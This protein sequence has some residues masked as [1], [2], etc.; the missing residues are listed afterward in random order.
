MSMI[1]FRPPGFGRFVIA[2]ATYFACI[3][4][5]H[6]LWP[7]TVLLFYTIGV[8]LI[9]VGMWMRLEPRR[10]NQ[11]ERLC[12]FCGYDMRATPHSCP[13]CDRAPANSPWLGEF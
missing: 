10:Q 11:R 5:A 6:W 13:E 8:P 2:A 12:Q 9:G 1:V 7:P 3:N 4:I